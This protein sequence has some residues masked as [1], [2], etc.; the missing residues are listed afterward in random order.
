MS[1]NLYKD[2]GDGCNAT[3]ISSAVG[4]AAVQLYWN[5]YT[6][7][8]SIGSIFSRGIYR[9]PYGE[10]LQPSYA[11]MPLLRSLD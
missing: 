8:S 3:N 7:T 10:S 5:A 2:E 11:V 1:E 6:S 4:Y 9:G